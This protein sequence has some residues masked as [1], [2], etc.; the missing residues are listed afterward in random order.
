MVATVQSLYGGRTIFNNPQEKL[1]GE[2][3]LDVVAST[4]PIL[5][6]DEPQ[7][8]EG[9]GVAGREALGTC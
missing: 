7:S 2:K 8:V 6:V 9:T 1:A 5:I 4:N 3:P